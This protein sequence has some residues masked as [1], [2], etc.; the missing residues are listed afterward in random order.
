MGNFAARDCPGYVVEFDNYSITWDDPMSAN[1]VLQEVPK[2]LSLSPHADGSGRMG[3]CG[4]GGA[5]F[6][7]QSKWIILDRMLLLSSA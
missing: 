1:S 3:G 7:W 2:M 5:G 6:V 4:Y